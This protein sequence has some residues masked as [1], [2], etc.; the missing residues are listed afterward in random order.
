MIAENA[1]TEITKQVIVLDEFFHNNRNKWP[2]VNN[3]NETTFLEDGYYY[4]LNN[5]NDEMQV[6]SKESNLHADDD[7]LITAKIDCIK[8]NVAGNYGLVWG[9]GQKPD[10]LN[11]F[12][13]NTHDSKFEVIHSGNGKQ[14]PIVQKSG[15][16]NSIKLRESTINEIS[17]V[18]IG[19]QLYFFINDPESPVFQSDWSGYPCYGNRVGFFTEPGQHIRAH[20]IQVR[21]LILKSARKIN[22]GDLLKPF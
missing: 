14:T 5:S 12:T 16:A 21:K 3:D 7:F 11:R 17:L 18:K 20:R 1:S 10:H 22:W 13:V 6:Y 4:M 2:V 19:N 15:I 8:S 9:V